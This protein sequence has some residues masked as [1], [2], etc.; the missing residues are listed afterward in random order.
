MK[1][2]KDSDENEFEGFL[3]EVDQNIDWQLETKPRPRRR[4]IVPED[5]QKKK[6][7]LVPLQQMTA[8][9]LFKLFVTV[10]FVKQSI[11]FTNANAKMKQRGRDKG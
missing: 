3:F 5:Q 1:S 2:F 8:F 6:G 11:L 7:V 4:K 10:E 9:P